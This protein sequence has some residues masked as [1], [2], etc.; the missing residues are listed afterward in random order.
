MLRTLLARQI[1]F[2]IGPASVHS[3]CPISS[4]VSATRRDTRAAIDGAT[5]AMLMIPLAAHPSVTRLD[6]YLESLGDSVNA[7]S[8]AS[9][10]RSYA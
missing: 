5:R 1:A 4:V 7:M 9:A 2:D 6:V 10:G 3:P 8:D